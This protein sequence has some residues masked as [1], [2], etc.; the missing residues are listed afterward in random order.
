M[1]RQLFRQGRAYCRHDDFTT[2]I[3]ANQI[4]KYTIQRLIRIDSVDRKLHKDLRILQSKLQ[5][6]Q[7]INV[8]TSHFHQVSIHR[9]NS[10]YGFILN[11]CELIYHSTAVQENG[12]AIKFNSFLNDREKMSR[13]FESFIRNFY[14]R[15]QR[16]FASG[17]EVINWKFAHDSEGNRMLFPRSK[18][19]ILTTSDPLT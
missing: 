14:R 9:N 8:Q 12:Q 10:F 3:L 1:R 5:S 19:G 4:L 15:E 7:D 13:L 17:A 16:D 2:N 18:T 11:I 6:I